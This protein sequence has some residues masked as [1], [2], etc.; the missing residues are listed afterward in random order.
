M[1]ADPVRPY[2][3]GADGG[4]GKADRHVVVKSC[5]RRSIA[6]G[7]IAEGKVFAAE[8]LRIAHHLVDTPT[9]RERN[10]L[11]FVWMH[12][13]DVKSLRAN[14]TSRAQNDE[15]HLAHVRSFPTVRTL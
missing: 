5:Q 14:R 12:A 7:L 2:V 8:L 4:G 3:A 11:E 10:D 15:T 6:H 9:C 1:R 13:H